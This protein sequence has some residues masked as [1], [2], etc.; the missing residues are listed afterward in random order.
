MPLPEAIDVNQS[1]LPNLRRALIIGFSIGL[2]MIIGVGLTLF[3]DYQKA[4]AVER[5]AAQMEAEW[6][7]KQASRHT[8]PP[9]SAPPSPAR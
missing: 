7:Q 8:Q 5:Q 1:K 9:A 3:R 4:A 2:L 6:H